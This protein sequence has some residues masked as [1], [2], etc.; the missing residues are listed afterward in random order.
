MIG[1]LGTMDTDGGWHA[2]AFW[3]AC[4]VFPRRY[5]PMSLF[6]FAYFSPSDSLRIASFLFRSN[7]RK[8]DTAD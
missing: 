2:L 3:I 6:S 7:G 4:N 5:T 8:D 1:S